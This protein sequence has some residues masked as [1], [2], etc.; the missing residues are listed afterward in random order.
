MFL[1]E[2]LLNLRGSDIPYNP[3]F[4][5][6]MVITTS[7]VNLFVDPHKITPNVTSH[8]K[9]EGLEVTVHP[10]EKILAFLEEFV[11]TI[12]IRSVN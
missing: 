6:Y 5:A 2:G 11:S 10:Y 9:S 7:Q 12:T 4:Y 8:F 3:V 1:F